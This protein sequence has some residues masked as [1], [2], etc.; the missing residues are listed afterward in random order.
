MLRTVIS[1]ISPKNAVNSSAKFMG[2]CPCHS[3]IEL[4]GILSWGWKSPIQRFQSPKNLPPGPGPHESGVLG[5]D[6]VAALCIQKSTRFN[7]TKYGAA[8]MIKTNLSTA[9]NPPRFTVFIVIRESRPLLS[10][11]VHILR[12]ESINRRP[13]VPLPNRDN[14]SIS[15]ASLSSSWKLQQAINRP[16]H[17]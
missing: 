4:L 1:L 17:A 3:E 2:K 7:L 10:S 11:A 6:M 5:Q 16:E 9:S 8:S 14:H 13:R 12:G 15:I